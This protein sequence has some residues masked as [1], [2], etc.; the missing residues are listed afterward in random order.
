MQ[1]RVQEVLKSL[2]KE[3]GLGEMLSLQTGLEVMMRR[4]SNGKK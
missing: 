3:W 4:K 1:D 2:E